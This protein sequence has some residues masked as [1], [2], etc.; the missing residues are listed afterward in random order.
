MSVFYPIVFAST[1]ILIFGLIEIALIRFLHRDWWG[2]R[3]VKWPA[4]ALPLIGVVCIVLW[5]LGM[6]NDIRWVLAIGATGTSLAFVLEVALMLSLPFSGALAFL[7]RALDWL[8]KRRRAKLSKPINEKRRVFLK[9]AAAA[10]PAI[11][12]TSGAAGIARGFGPILLPRVEMTFP[13]LPP[14]LDGVKILQLSDMHLGLY[15]HLAQLEEVLTNAKKHAP[16]VILITGDISDQ[17]DILPDV[18]RM[19]AEFNA[20][21]GHL[22]SLGNHEYYRGI[23]A[24]RRIFDAGPV[25][26]VIDRHAVLPVRGTALVIAG[27]DDPRWLGR[28][29]T[30][31]LEASV[32][33]AMNGAPSD[34][35]IV[36]MSHR[37][38]GLNIATKWNIPLTL[39]GHTHGSQVGLF[40]RSVF[41]PLMPE[42]Y[43]WGRYQKGAS[44]LYT[45]A[46]VGHWFPFRLGCPPEAP[47]IVLRKA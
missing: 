29:D 42:R 2:K 45:S 47:I 26:L 13:N 6:V 46:G 44:Q 9:T 25:P 23:E 33:A 27:A 20:P 19:I 43:L 10:L 18:L 24:V 35:F 5:S 14:A 3:W 15:Q 7:N 21:L 32:G 4:I 8:H 40:R 16:D 36:L 37:P 41:E 31:F 17:L 34:S 38:E 11:S 1:V 39:A 22:A 30:K 12:L 28:D